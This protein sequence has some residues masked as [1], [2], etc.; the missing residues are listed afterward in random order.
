MLKKCLMWEATGWRASAGVEMHFPFMCFVSTSKEQSRPLSSASTTPTSG[1]KN[2]EF[3]K[4]ALVQTLC[5]DE[6][7]EWI[8]ETQNK[9]E[10]A[11]QSAQAKLSTQK[12][13]KTMLQST[14]TR[15]RTP[16]LQCKRE[17]CWT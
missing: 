17:L 16:T 15:A 12:S 6:T 7:L 9:L 3:I 5:N 13:F 11:M 4:E 14:S 1:I 8:N 2:V 10:V